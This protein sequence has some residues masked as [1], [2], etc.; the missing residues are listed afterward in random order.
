MK[1]EENEPGRE[2]RAVAKEKAAGLHRGIGILKR[3]QFGGK[4]KNEKHGKSK[5]AG[6]KLA[7]NHP[8]ESV[9]NRKGLLGDERV[10]GKGRR[11]KSV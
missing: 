10:G 9:E 6:M 2:M 3:E 7:E 8:T 11:N 5:K 1:T 4:V